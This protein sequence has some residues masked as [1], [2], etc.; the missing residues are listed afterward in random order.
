MIIASYNCITTIRIIRKR[1][2]VPQLVVHAQPWFTQS[3][4]GIYKS[5]LCLRH[6]STKTGRK[7]RRC[8]INLGGE[9]LNVWIQTLPKRVKEFR[10]RSLKHSSSKWKHLQYL[11]IGITI[12]ARI[13]VVSVL[14]DKDHPRL[15]SR[16]SLF[17]KSRKVCARE[18]CESHLAT[19]Q[20]TVESRIDRPK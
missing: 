15:F 16:L 11:S 12:T 5:P 7:R 13:F 18:L 17:A 20:L 4:L 3:S 14:N 9:Y 8:I 6:T 19:S 10:R 2:Q 1:K